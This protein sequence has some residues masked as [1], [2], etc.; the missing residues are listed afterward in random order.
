MQRPS[1]F[2]ADS[3]SLAENQFSYETYTDS[4]QPPIPQSDVQNLEADLDAKLDDGLGTT[5]LLFAPYTLNPVRCEFY[6]SCGC[7]Q[8]FTTAIVS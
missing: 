6:H 8:L 2:I 4:Y 7:V 5:S 1:V 3:G